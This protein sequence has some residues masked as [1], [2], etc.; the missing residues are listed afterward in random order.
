MEKFEF[1]ISAD[2]AGIPLKK[3]IKTKYHFSSRLMTKI[4]YQDLLMLNG[5]SVPGYYTGE[6]GDI[7]TVSIPDEI[8]HFEPEDIPLDIIYEDSD[9]IVLNKQPGFTCHPT[10]G[11]KE[12]TI[13]N[14]VMKHMLDNNQSY[15]IRFINRLDMD[16]SGVLLIGKNGFVQAEIIKQMND[17][18]TEKKYLALVSGIIK[19]DRFLI[20]LPIGHSPEGIT[21]EVVAENTLGSYPSKT[22]VN[23]L[24]RFP[25]S[26]ELNDITLV[27]LRLLTGR[28]HQIRV[29]MSHIGHPLLGDGLYGGPMDLINRQ[30]LHAESFSCIH[31]VTKET[32]LFKAKI[33]QD[34][35]DL[36]NKISNPS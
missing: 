24:E 12:H 5:I 14:G 17:S 33:P 10:K 16:T 35:E 15:K 34:M 29:H 18:I 20:D 28:T 9:F 32:V 23:V 36:I 2:E 4:K 22:E 11:H 25:H 6:I 8:S 21:R 13:A 7:V 27:Q 3:V 30:A 31:P 1:T 19:E 26:N